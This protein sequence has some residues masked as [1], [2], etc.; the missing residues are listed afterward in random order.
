MVFVALGWGK[1]GFTAGEVAAAHQTLL[2]QLAEVAVDGGQAHGQG[3]APQSGVQVL[4]G[5]F[6]AGEHQL[7]EELVLFGQ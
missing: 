3:C 4:A 1:K 2:L 5:Q 6:L 7:L